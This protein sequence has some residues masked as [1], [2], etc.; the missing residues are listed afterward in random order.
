M[1]WVGWLGDPVGVSTGVTVLDLPDGEIDQIF[2]GE[3]LGDPA[4][5]RFREVQIRE[6]PFMDLGLD[7]LLPWP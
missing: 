7:V 1:N 3:K 5:L 4:I 6:R 2:R